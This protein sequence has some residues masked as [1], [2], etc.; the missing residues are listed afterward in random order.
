MTRR[1]CLDTETTGISWRGG[2]RICEVAA[3]EIDDTYAPV[4]YFHAYVNPQRHIPYEVTRIHHITDRKVRLCPAFP[5]I[6]EAF[7]DFVAG[8]RLYA[9]NMPFDHGFLDAE[10]QRAGRLPLAEMGCEC[11]CTLSLARR[12]FRGM[13]NTLD[14]LCERFGIDETERRT[15]GHGALTDSMLLV[16]ILAHLEG[17]EELLAGAAPLLPD[18]SNLAPPEARRLAA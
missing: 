8:A 13:R 3:V 16:S 17:N 10:L 18:A 5:G 9:H 11:L 12:R 15:K 6:A 2:D 14:I 7:C 4:A 1:I